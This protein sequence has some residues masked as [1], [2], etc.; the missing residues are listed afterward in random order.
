MQF[1]NLALVV[2][3]AALSTTALAEFV[4]LTSLPT[5]TNLAVLTDID[6]YVSSL[7]NFITS[8]LGAELTASSALYA[9]ASAQSA[10]AS[11]VATASYDIDS[12]VT[13]VGALETFTST[14]AWYM[15]LPSDVKSYYDKN[16][17]EVQSLLNEAVNGEN[18][19]TTAAS[20]SGTGSAAGA[21]ATGSA[22]GAKPTGAA[23]GKVVGVVGA[24]VAAAFAGVMAL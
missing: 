18:A 12:Q 15:A 5:P 14:P 22:A 16:N 17:A 8:K 24:G 21:S 4:I 6:S 1:K 19:T 9:A 2:S 20:A 11:F 3:V 23:M 7:Q 13:E 10:L